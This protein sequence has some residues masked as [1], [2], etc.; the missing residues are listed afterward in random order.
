MGKHAMIHELKVKLHVQSRIYVNFFEKR[1]L[2]RQY[3]I[4]MKVHLSN[5]STFFFQA[6]NVTQFFDRCTSQIKIQRIILR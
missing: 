2:T 5:F 3:K 6:F 4:S 1:F